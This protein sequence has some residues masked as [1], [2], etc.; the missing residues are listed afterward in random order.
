MTPHNPPWVEEELILALDLYLRKGLLSKENP[1]VKDLSDKLGALP[2]HFNRPNL[3]NFRNPTGVYF[4]LASFATL[5]PNHPSSSIDYS[6]RAA[7]VWERYASD[8]DALAEAAEAIRQSRKLPMLL[9]TETTN[10]GIIEMETDEHYGEQFKVSL[11]SQGIEVDKREQHLILAYRD[12]LEGKG[13][14]VKRHI[15]SPSGTSSPIV[16]DLV[17][18]TVSMIYKAKG[19]IRRTSV[20]MAI[21]QLLDYRRFEQMPMNLAVLL[22]RQPSRD[23]VE[24]IRSVPASAVWRTKDSFINA[25]P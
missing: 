4:H 21:G 18:E 19:D 2:F 8:E 17:D 3:K 13:H 16:C 25:K 15:Y 9:P 23:L 24:F 7:E 10:S 1:A 11:T 20:R 22:P 12:H 5:D 6:K 14:K